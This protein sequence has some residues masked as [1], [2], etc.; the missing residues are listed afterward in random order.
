MD[1]YTWIAFW[2]KNRW[3]A[4]L[5]DRALMTSGSTLKAAVEGLRA[6]IKPTD[7]GWSRIELHPYQGCDL[8]G[9]ERSFTDAYWLVDDGGNR[10]E[11]EPSKT[12]RYA[13]TFDG[14]QILTAAWLSCSDKNRQAILSNLLRRAEDLHNTTA[15]DSLSI[16]MYRLVA[17][18]QN[19]PEP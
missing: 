19:L 8:R 18:M 7:K 9:D 11:T 16:A 6:L 12:T 3:V 15:D 1:R 5:N 13:G 14:F 10:Y 4:G 2:E 17:V